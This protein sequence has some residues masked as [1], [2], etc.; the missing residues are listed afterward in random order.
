MKTGKFSTE[1]MNT[2][3]AALGCTYSFSFEFP[4]GTKI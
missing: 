3:A 2:I 1:E 4:D